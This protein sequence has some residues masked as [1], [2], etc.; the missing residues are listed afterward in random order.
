M[1]AEDLEV[2][3]EDML[4]V[5]AASAFTLRG[6][7]G[8][9]ALDEHVMTAMGKVPRHEFVPIEL[10]PYAYANIPLPIG[11]AKTI[12]QPFIV[13]LMTDLLDIEPH[14][15]VLEIGTGL[16]YQAAILAQLARKVY[17]VEII[18]ELGQAAKQRLRQ[19]RCSNVELKIA[20][21]YH[22]WSEH[23]PFD[24]VIVTAAPDLIPP[25]LIHQLKA[26]GKMV[27]PAGL[28]DAQKLILAEKLANGRM[29]MKEILSVR[30]SQL[31]GTGS[32]L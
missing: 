26:G 2:L 10:Q 5:I 12:S 29:T 23:A 21:G 14:D 3:R 19:Q 16:G 7:I 11:F 25:P 28:P 17:S 31:E 1:R 4:T 20:D 18:E 8:K 15:S 13:A 6:T 22:G 9:S 32:D 30:F 27:I 24:K